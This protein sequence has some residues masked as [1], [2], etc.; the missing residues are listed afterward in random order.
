MRLTSS[1]LK[2][3]GF[4]YESK[5][6]V[7]IVTVTINWISISNQVWNN[8]YFSVNYKSR[9]PLSPIDLL[10]VTAVRNAYGTRDN[11]NSKTDNDYAFGAF[12]F[13]PE[14]NDYQLPL[15]TILTFDE[16]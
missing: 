16:T 12:D 13:E 5:H 7:P 11:P 10:F 1:C 8:Y 15:L 6:T 4:K 9:L 2:N 3:I 14:L